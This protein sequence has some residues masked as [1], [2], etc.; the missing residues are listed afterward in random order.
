MQYDNNIS[1]NQVFKQI[2][3][4]KDKINS[5][6]IDFILSVKVQVNGN[7]KLSDKQ[8]SKLWNI[9]HKAIKTKTIKNDIP[10]YL[11]SEPKTIKAI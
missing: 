2:L 10:A 11:Y 6:E 8:Y 4:N 5:W 7:N 1:L 3:E 9:K